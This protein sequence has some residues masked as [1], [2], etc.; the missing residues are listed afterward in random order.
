MVRCERCG[1]EFKNVHALR[2]H[3][4]S[5]NANGVIEKPDLKSISEMI[6]KVKALAEEVGGINELKAICEAL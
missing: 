6:R 1:R 3:H 4:V 5:C 2:I